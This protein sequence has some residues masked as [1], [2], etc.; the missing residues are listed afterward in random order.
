MGAELSPKGI[1]ECQIQPIALLMEQRIVQIA[2][3]GVQ[4]LMSENVHDVENHSTADVIGE[5][6]KRIA[7][8][9]RR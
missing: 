3:G 9:A 4:V 1:G 6:G 5:C 2:L 8:I 7:K